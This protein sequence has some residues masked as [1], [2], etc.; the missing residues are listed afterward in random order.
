[1][2][3]SWTAWKP[4]GT[5]GGGG[6]EVPFCELHSE[7]LEEL[8][9]FS[10][11]FALPKKEQK[12]KKKIKKLQLFHHP[13]F[14]FVSWAQTISSLAD[15]QIKIYSSTLVS[16]NHYYYS[17]IMHFAKTIETSSAQWLKTVLKRSKQYRTTYNNNNRSGNTQTHTHTHPKSLDKHMNWFASFPPAANER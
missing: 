10:T 9:V 13:R 1:M 16:L 14:V 15:I 5:G 12:E 4:G 6:S 11:F 7:N 2:L 17:C 8:W 3:E